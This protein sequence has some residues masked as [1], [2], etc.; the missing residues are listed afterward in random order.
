MAVSDAIQTLLSGDSTLVSLIANSS[1]IYYQGPPKRAVMPCVV[2]QKQSGMPTWAFQGSPYKTEV[3]LVKA[4]VKVQGPS[5]FAELTSAQAIDDRINQLLGD[6]DL[7]VP[8][9]TLLGKVRRESDVSP[10]WEVD[11]PDKYQHIGGTYRIV[12]Q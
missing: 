8:G 12:Y 3:W 11:G 2:Y 1:A 9:S 10:Y 4:I 6:S 5:H 7:S